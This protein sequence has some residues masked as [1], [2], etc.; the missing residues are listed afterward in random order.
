MRNIGIR[1]AGFAWM[2]L[3]SMLIASG[4][5][6]GILGIAGGILVRAKPDTTRVI[7]YDPSRVASFAPIP[8]AA[9]VLLT[10]LFILRARRLQD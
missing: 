1:I 7:N 9:G 2:F 8:F 10:I 3:A 6:L 4:F 5:A